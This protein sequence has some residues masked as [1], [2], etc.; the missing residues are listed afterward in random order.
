MAGREIE[1]ELPITEHPAYKYAS[2]SETLF[3]TSRDGLHFK[4]W[5]EA[6]IR[7]GPRKERWIYGATFAHYGLLVTKPEAAGMPD[8]LSLYVNDGGGWT[9]RGKASRFRRYTLRI[10]GFVSAQA[11]LSGGELLT[12]PLVFQG[13]ELV[14]NFST[15]AAGSVQVEMRDVEGS[16]IPGFALCDSGEIFGDRIERIVTWD[17]ASNVSKLSGKPIRLRFVL[18]DADLYSIRFR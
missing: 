16:P 5:G 17:G 3:M 10:D 11:P 9:Q 15:S 12:K 18:K 1:K 8:E 13:K 7:P 4:R 14:M 6:F 2:I